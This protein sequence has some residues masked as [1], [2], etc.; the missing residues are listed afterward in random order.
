MKVDKK[1][2]G[3]RVQR[4]KTGQKKSIFGTIIGMRKEDGLSEITSND[5]ER[6][7][8]YLVKWDH[9]PKE[10]HSWVASRLLIPLWSGEIQNPQV[11]TVNE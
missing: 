1:Y 3:D 11:E 8:E 5:D 7:I 9:P 10:R 4:K 2:V 6:N